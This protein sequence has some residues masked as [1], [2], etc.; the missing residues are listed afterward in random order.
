[1]GSGTQD[2]PAPRVR[3]TPPEPRP[4]Q[5]P[6]EPR[7]ANVQPPPQPR[8]RQLPPQPRERQPPPTKKTDALKF[9][10]DVAIS[11]SQQ[12][13]WTSQSLDTAKMLKSSISFIMLL[14]CGFTL[15]SIIEDDV[16]FPETIQEYDVII[17]SVELDD[18][19]VI[20]KACPPGQQLDISGICREVW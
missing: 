8:E 16:L 6:P 4:R 14:I 18:S 15:S 10:N 12:S 5:P 17:K 9:D 1:M 3:Q 7:R 19:P 2:P 20:G 11:T 13:G